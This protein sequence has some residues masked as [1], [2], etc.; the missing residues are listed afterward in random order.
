MNNTKIYR[1]AIKLWM[2][3]MV[4]WALLGLILHNFLLSFIGI[5]INVILINYYGWLIEIEKIKY[6]TLEEDLIKCFKKR[7]IEVEQI[8]VTNGAAKYMIIVKRK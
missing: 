8:K 7:N 4:V 5:M 3:L 2:V 6:R 1:F